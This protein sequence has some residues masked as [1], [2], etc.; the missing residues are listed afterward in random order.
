MDIFTHTL[1]GLAAG[2]CLVFC[3]KR[4]WREKGGIFLLSALGGALPDIDAISLWSRFDGTIG[5]LLGL[6]HPGKVI[7]SE[8][9]WYSH[10]GF[11][12]SLTAAVLFTFFLSL[13]FYFFTP[14]KEKNKLSP[15]KRF[16]RNGW[17]LLG[18]ICGYLIHLLED[19]VTPGGP[20][21]G[22]RLLFPSEI[23]LGGT[24]DIW[25]WN[26]YDLFLIVCFVLILNLIFLFISNFRKINIKIPLL[27]FLTGCLFMVIQ[28]KTRGYDFNSRSSTT[29]EKESRRI[30]RELL[31]DPLYTPME[32]LDRKLIIPF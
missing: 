32:Q 3:A 26:N 18:F 22:I 8:K 23:Y 27:I 15:G 13:L 24:G 21:G 1:S 17:M 11:M 14:K 28:I 25:W 29:S 4:G 9:F 2:S 5:K 31:G 19:M 12:H 6:S 20:W 7:Y 30:Q 10:H 16:F